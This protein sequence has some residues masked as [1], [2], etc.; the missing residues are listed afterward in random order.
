MKI[1][2][3]SPKYEGPLELA[4]SYGTHFSVRNEDGKVMGSK[5]HAE[6]LKKA[7]KYEKIFPID[8]IHPLTAEREESL[9]I[10]E[11]R[12]VPTRMTGPNGMVSQAL[13][14]ETKH[15][16]RVIT[17]SRIQDGRI[18]YGVRNGQNETVYKRVEDID[19]GLIREYEQKRPQKKRYPLRNRRRNV[20]E[21]IHEN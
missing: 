8:P 14:K 2:K 12:S 6:K 16:S 20:N 21:N 9:T 5:V 13:P 4:Q 10:E 17:T 11:T 15:D 18:A 3:L 19:E 7:K 1:K